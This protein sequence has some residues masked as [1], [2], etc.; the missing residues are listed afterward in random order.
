MSR[1]SD[2]YDA[3][4]VEDSNLSFFRLRNLR[5]AVPTRKDLVDRQIVI[6]LK[7]SAARS[8]HERRRGVSTDG[9][10]TLNFTVYGVMVPKTLLQYDG[11]LENSEGLASTMCFL[12]ERGGGGR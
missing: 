2:A 8:K 9:L 3:A 6:A 5:E 1:L 7:D 10:N 4:A 11:S 12:G